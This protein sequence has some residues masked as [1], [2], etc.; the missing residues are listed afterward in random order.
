MTAEYEEVKTMKRVIEFAEKGFDSIIAI[1]VVLLL[2]EALPRFHIVSA[3]ILPPFST[4]AVTFATL[5]GSGEMTLHVV[6]SL[7]RALGGFTLSVIIGIPLGF[8]LGWSKRAERMLDPLLQLCRNTATLAMYPLFILVFG[9]GESSK[10]AIIVW[11]AVWPILINTIAGVRSMDPLLLK[12]A[13]SM[14]VSGLPLFY[15]VILPLAFPFMFTGIRL[16]AS[17]SVIILVAAEMIGAG[18][19]LGYYVFNREAYFMV[20]EMYAAIIM[21]IILGITINY[22]LVACEKRISRWKEQVVEV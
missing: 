20:K 19:G 22:A 13:R 3:E 4:V 17:R 2:W 5:I 18:S 10:I 12:A 15:K 7:K 1:A 9:L 21:L 14:G 8:L 11:G 16:A 6:A